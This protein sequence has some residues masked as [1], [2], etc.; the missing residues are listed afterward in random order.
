[1]LDAA[2]NVGAPDC[3]RNSFTSHIC[4]SQL[5]SR[6]PNIADIVEL[7]KRGLMGM[8]CEVE[9]WRCL[10]SFNFWGDVKDKG[11]GGNADLFMYRYSFAVNTR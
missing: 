7:T 10:F 8:E 11:G 2:M 3:D 6:D 5:E 1:M 9:F 4:V